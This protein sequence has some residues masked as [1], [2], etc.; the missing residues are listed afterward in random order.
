MRILY[1]LLLILPVST[2]SQNKKFNKADRESLSEIESENKLLAS[3]PGQIIPYLEGQFKKAGLSPL[4]AAGFIQVTNIDAG[5]KIQPATTSFEV[6]NQQLV[7]EQEFF[8]LAFSANGNVKS[9]TS[10]SMREANSAWFLDIKDWMNENATNTQY[11]VSKA[12]YEEAK[13]V[14]KRKAQALIVYNSSSKAD[15]VS[16][17]KASNL[18]PLS[19]PVIYVTSAGFKKHI[20]DDIS[21]Y[22][23]SLK[24]NIAADKQ[25]KT[26][27]AAFLNNKSANTI[28]ICTPYIQITPQEMNPSGATALATLVSLLKKSKSKNNNYLFIAFSDDR[29]NTPTFNYWPSAVLTGMNIRYAVNLGNLGNYNNAK[30]LTINNI[31]SNWIGTFTTAAGQLNAKF[32]KENIPSTVMPGNSNTPVFYTSTQSNTTTEIDAPGELEIVHFV[33]RLVETTDNK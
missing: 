21:T 2:F 17:D 28:I 19:I 13:K 22:D 33:Q 9:E 10:P 24:V 12:I 7:L 20:N 11:N 27:V 25:A 26:S 15:N 4:N 30:E 18:P 1:I 5:K 32:N 23:V 29:L 31:P 8:P 14:A 6:N 16:F 3:T